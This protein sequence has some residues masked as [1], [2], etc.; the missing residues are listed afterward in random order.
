MLIDHIG[1]IFFSENYLFRMIGRLSMPLFA[2]CIA[3]GGKNTH[4]IDEYIKRVLLVALISQIPYMCMINELKLNICFLWV[5]GL[6]LIKYLIKPVNK[7]LKILFTTESIILCNLIP[8]DY[9]VYGLV[10][11]LIIYLYMVQ[12]NNDKKMYF[13]WGILHIVKILFDM[14][15]GVLQIFT[16]PT[17]P[18]IE[19]CNKYGLEEK[20]LKSIW[21]EYFYPLHITILLLI[22]YVYR[23]II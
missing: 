7:F 13:S 8:I 6:F 22:L 12:E 19:I 9:G 4:N 16:I 14:Q 17:I 15:S 5:I 1:I 18:L 3:R 2:Y 20:K 10:Y 21:I 11:M 23:A